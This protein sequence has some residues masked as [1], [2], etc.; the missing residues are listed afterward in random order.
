MKTVILSILLLSSGLQAHEHR[1]H[2][3]HQHGAGKIGIAFEGANG[4]MDLK[5][6]SESI[7]GFEHQAKSTKHKAA[8]KAGLKS[9]EEKIGALVVFDPALQCVISTDKVEVVKEK[10]SSHSDT[11]GIYTI[12][13]SKSPLGSTITF[14]FQKEFPRIKDLDVEVVADSL[15][16]SIEVKESG[17]RLELK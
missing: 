17:A 15:Q 2:G 6:P 1:H 9:L 13:C 7:F 14:N 12:K 11:V 10:R 3:S 5:I 16:K 8:Q 4:K